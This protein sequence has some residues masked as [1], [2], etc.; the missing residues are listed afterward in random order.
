M[1]ERA[2]HD[3]RNIGATLQQQARALGDPT[4]Y[5]IFGYLADADQPVDIAE[6]TAR[7]EVNHNA[8][9]QHL[10]KLVHA[11]LVV[12]GHARA[13]GRGRP[14]LIYRVNPAVASRWG[15]IGPYERLSVLLAEVVKTGD[16]PVDVGRRS[17]R[18][19][20][21]VAEPDANSVAVVT[22]A[23][24]RQGFDPVVRRR[25]GRVEVVLRRCPFEAAALTDAGT[26]CAIH[27]G[28]AQGLAALTDE[29]IIVDELVARDPRRA[30]CRLL[31]H[32]APAT[33]D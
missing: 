2:P 33:H 25:G 4:R 26:V 14:R 10:A 24:E 11:D 1:A 17:V 18:R 27:L 32:F 6:L 19:Q 20:R 9:R 15:I 12:E 23:M 5:A 31:M 29:R 13:E 16:A 28:M 8:V 22:E 3:A 7:F 21:F 30:N